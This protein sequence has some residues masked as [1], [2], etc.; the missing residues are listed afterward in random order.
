HLPVGRAGHIP[1]LSQA[2]GRMPAATAQSRTVLDCSWL[3][4]ILAR[5]CQRKR[6]IPGRATGNVYCAVQDGARQLRAPALQT[7][8]RESPPIRSISPA[9]SGAVP[10]NP[11]CTYPSS[12]IVPT[13]RAIPPGRAIRPLVDWPREVLR[14][15]DDTRT[16]ATH[17]TWPGPTRSVAGA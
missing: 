12:Q 14:A 1:V 2:I 10:G 11:R 4:R 17:P 8:E 6:A 5:Y 13:A 16:A 3:S 15:P 7:I 9:R